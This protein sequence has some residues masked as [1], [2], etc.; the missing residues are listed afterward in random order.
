MAV[1]AVAQRHFRTIPR[2]VA[3]ARDFNRIEV[4]GFCPNHVESSLAGFEGAVDNALERISA[5]RA[6]RDPLDFNLLLNLVGLLAVRNPGMRESVRLAEEQ[7]TKTFVARTLATRQGFDAAYAA[8]VRAGALDVDDNLSY[9]EM[10]EFIDHDRYAIEV[11]TTQY[12]ELELELL[13]TILPLLG[14]RKWI[15]RPQHAMSWT[16]A[17]G[18]RDLGT[19]GGQGSRAIDV[20][21]R[22]QIVGFAQNKA[23][24][25]R[26]FV[27]TAQRGMLDLNRYLRHA[28]HGLVVDDAL[29]INDSGAIVATSNAGL[30]LLWP[31]QKCGCG[32][33]LGPVVAPAVVKAGVPLQASVAFVDEDH[34]GTRGVTW[35][36]GDGSGAQ[37]GRMRESDAAGNA[38]ASHSF[39][40]PGI[41]TVTA[42]VVDRS[43]RSTA[44][45]H[46]VVVTA[47]SGGAVAGAG[48][49]M[50]PAGAFAQTPRYAGKASFRLIAPTERTAQ[51][52]RV[53]A[54]LQFDLPGLNF[55]SQDFHLLGRQGTQQVFEGNGTA[56][57]AA[58]Y[59]F[60][61][62]TSAAVPGGEQGSFVLKIWHTDPASHKDVVDY[63]NARA[64]SGI[65]P[66]RVTD[67]S[68]VL[69]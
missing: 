36:W 56:G 42:T 53:P 64:P 34:V 11:P 18:T 47:P 25:P 21:A 44:V 67:G 28:P 1:D 46:D 45:S 6:I 24:K 43:G 59:K 5:A 35:S 54:M 8:A 20:N 32:H 38:E 48:T 13:D 33:A 58:G 14:A 30:V 3:S 49:L 16:R 52:E 62:S 69:E 37:A 57:G 29:A 61:L 40:A 26:A 2:N 31:D 63:D 65:A 39:A 9:E 17:T 27:W 66:G 7:S 60:R 51:A 68:I 55:R 19:L 22:G 41:Y 50:S 12:V 10:R 4:A 23:G 15:N